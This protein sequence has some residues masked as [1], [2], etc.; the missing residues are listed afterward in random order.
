MVRKFILDTDWFT[1]CDDC[2]ALRFLLGNLDEK[3]QLLGINVNA[4]TEY[5][6]ASVKAFLEDA[7]VEYPIALDEENMYLGA[8]RYQKNMAHGSIYTNRDAEKSVEFYK[9]I[10]E[11]NDNVEILSIG[12]LS[13]IEKVFRQYPELAQNKIKKI[14]VCIQK[15]Q[16]TVSLI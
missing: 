3:H 12:F 8:T 2:I 14:W 1:D 6:Y 5:S 9:R 13:S 16:Q 10:L 7:G 11:Q 4:T 15:W